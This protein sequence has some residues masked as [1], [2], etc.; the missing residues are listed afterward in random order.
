MRIVIRVFLLVLLSAIA[1][2][3]QTSSVTSNTQQDEAQRKKLVEYLESQELKIQ[4]SFTCSFTG[5][6]LSIPEDLQG[7]LAQAFPEYRFHIA[8]MVV[9]IDLPPKKY[10][11]ILIT[12]TATEEVEG[13]V[14]GNYWT[15]PPSVSFEGILKGHQ[16]KSKEEAISKI[17]TLVMLLVH[18]SNDT[19]G[20]AKIHRGKVKVELIRGD[21]VFRI[22]EVKID[23][24][25]RFGRLAV[26]GPDG[27]RMRYFV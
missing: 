23:K 15:L 4:K 12:N 20:N 17:K 18:T 7:Q 1:L 14:W 3:A 16:A 9:F 26:T 5:E 6:F 27:K 2:V 11:L 24:R 21:G 19:V 13:F 10:D 8:K 22:L 25:L